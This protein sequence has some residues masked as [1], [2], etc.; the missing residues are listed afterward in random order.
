MMASDSHSTKHRWTRLENDELL[1]CYYTVDP[2]KR[3]FRVRLFDL[4]HKRNPGHEEYT[5]QRLAGQVSSLLRRKVFSELELEEIKFRATSADSINSARSSEPVNC[6]VSCSPSELS[7]ETTNLE[8]NA[9]LP[10]IENDLI[11]LREEILCKLTK[12]LNTP[13]LCL[14]SLQTVPYNKFKKKLCD[15]NKV[16]CTIPTW[17]LSELHHLMYC[18]ALTIVEHCGVAIQPSQATPP[19]GPPAWKSR[20]LSNIKQLQGDLSRFCSFK[21]GHLHRRSTISKLFKRYN[22]HCDSDIDEACEYVNQRIRAYTCRLKRYESKQLSFRQNQMFKHR[23]H[24]FFDMLNSP[25]QSVNSVPSVDDVLRFWKGLWER[26]CQYD[27]SILSHVSGD[28]GAVEP[29]ESPVITEELFMYSVARIKNWKAPG[30]DGLHGFWIKKFTSLH[31]RLCGYL[32]DLLAGKSHIDPWL[33]QGRTTLIMKNPKRGAV[34]SNYR[35]ITCLPTLWKFFFIS[36][37]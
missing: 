36:Y 21:K 17:S 24:A 26:P 28:L 7:T 1:Y 15:I 12:L 31:C 23:K 35:P 5:E 4:W 18:A 33:L 27:V 25:P 3:G 2:S 30:P 10:P 16:L 14:P 29:M 11:T 8:S 32:N 22:I 20:L 6:S 19:S 13:K 9:E 37:Q 34:P